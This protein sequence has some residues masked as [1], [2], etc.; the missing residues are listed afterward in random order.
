MTQKLFNVL[1]LDE[2]KEIETAMLA[3]TDL[4]VEKFFKNGSICKAYYDLPEANQHLPKI[5]ERVKQIYTRPHKFANSYT[6]IYYNGGNLFLHTDR[7]GLDITISCCIKKA[8]EDAWPLNISTKPWSGA[9][10]DNVDHNPWL[11]DYLS[12]DLDP[13]DMA[14]T[15]GRRYP[16]WR[17]T[18]LCEP[19]GYAIYAFYHWSWIEVDTETK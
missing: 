13:G 5:E 7:K 2:C 8:S 6:R 16:H 15:E 18:L 3:R 9:W 1:T 12:V 14:I 11:M 4:K 17:D 19:E 10:N